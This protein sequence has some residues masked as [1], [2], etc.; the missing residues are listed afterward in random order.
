MNT[1]N[2]TLYINGE[3]LGTNRSDIFIPIE[4]GALLILGRDQDSYGGT[5]TQVDVFFGRCAGGYKDNLS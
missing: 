2:T 3:F 5:F 1:K 4:E